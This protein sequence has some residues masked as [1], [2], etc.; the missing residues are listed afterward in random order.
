[1]II[2]AAIVIGA[3]AAA[4]ML[5]L[6]FLFEAFRPSDSL[7][8]VN[9]PK[10]SPPTLYFTF[11]DGPN[12]R[13]TPPLLDALNNT[14]AR[15]T[16]F[17]IDEHITEETAPIVRRIADDG[18]AIALHTG[19]RRPVVMDPD[20]LAVQLQ[21]AASRIEAITGRAPCKL[22][23]PH[24]GWRSLTMYRGLRK[25]GYRLAGW[26]WG[27][28]DWDW[29]RAPRGDAIAK[30]LARKASAGDIIVIHDG[31]HKNPNA[32]RRHAAEAIRRIVPV[33]EKRGFRFGTL[34]EPVHPRPD[35]SFDGSD[36][37]VEQRAHFLCQHCR[38]ER[39]LKKLIL[40]AE[41]AVVEHRVIGVSRDEE[42]AN[43]RQAL[44]NLTGQRAAVHAGHDEVGDQ[45]GRR[46]RQCVEQ[47]ERLFGATGRGDAIAGPRQ[48]SRE[49][50]PKRPLVFDEQNQ[51]RAGRFAS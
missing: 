34:C 51:L 39:L 42:H 45:Q 14:R 15:A 7:W 40:R 13:W 46:G 2:V 12:A 33:L 9:A 25:A 35:A 44:P 18:H 11:D 6:P 26:S 32:D 37:G 43:L 36:A 48:R 19:S 27:M 16:F 28:W 50:I 10:G 38:R 17:L 22:F 24:A 5:P 41:H 49:Q 23:R 47:P 21:R 4:H 3:V 29:W 31:H 30:R 1:M 8:H 20:E